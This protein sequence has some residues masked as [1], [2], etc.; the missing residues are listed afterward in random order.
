[1]ASG[2]P[3]FERPPVI[4]VAI[5]VQFETLPLTTAHLGVLW[6]DYREKLP[7]LREVAPL[8]GVVERFGV[9]QRPARPRI[10]FVEHTTNRVWFLSEAEDEL[11][12]AQA[13]RFIYNWRAAKER[14]GREYPRFEAVEA[15]FLS[16]FETLGAF[17]ARND[18]DE[19][20]ITQCE[21]TYV[22]H[23]LP[24]EDVW[25]THAEAGRA[26]TL[27]SETNRFFF[28]P[29]AE[30]IRASARFLIRAPDENVAG[31]LHIELEPRYF[32]EDDTPLLLLKLTARGAP[33][34]KGLEGA[35]D[36]FAIGREWIV[37]GFADITSPEMHRIWGRR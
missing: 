3:N 10:A 23:I 14:D 22:N 12:Q 18:L 4:E 34:G 9:R 8:E 15:G 17:L 11:V 32:V 36:F 6:Q 19:P 13:D 7:K 16:A 31:R 27:V 33:L 21:V 28:L 24:A 2:T 37:R 35:R 30:D 26:V 29:T 5:G 20:N 25:H 1:M